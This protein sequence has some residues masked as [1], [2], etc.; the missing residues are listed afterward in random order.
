MESCSFLIRVPRSALSMNHGLYT[1]KQ[2]LTFQG[3]KALKPRHRIPGV[4]SQMGGHIKRSYVTGAR[5]A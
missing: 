1:V 5:M 4:Y 2:E 3:H